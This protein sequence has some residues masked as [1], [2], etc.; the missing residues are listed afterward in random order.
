MRAHLESAA[1]RHRMLSP[2]LFTAPAWNSNRTPRERLA[3]ANNALVT[4]LDRPRKSG[5]RADAPTPA[6]SPGG[7]SGLRRDLT[8]QDAHSQG[9]RAARSP[10]PAPAE[11]D[12]LLADLGARRRGLSFPARPC[13]KEGERPRPATNL[14]TPAAS[15]HDRHPASHRVCV[16]CR[17]RG[18]RR[19]GWTG[20]GRVVWRR[21]R[22]WLPQ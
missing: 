13:P 17:E 3:S 2:C 11:P 5:W 1:Q 22:W 16:E 20:P 7:T 8:A 15:A 19:R 10:R 14:P 9:S 18:P 12:R 21:G 4:V 6:C